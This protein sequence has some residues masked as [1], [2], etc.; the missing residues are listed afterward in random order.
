MLGFQPAFTRLPMAAFSGYL[1]NF[2]PG[3]LDQLVFFR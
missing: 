3:S 2:D 1:K